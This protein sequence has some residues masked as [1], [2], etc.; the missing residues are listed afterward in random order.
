MYESKLLSLLNTFS[1]KEMRELTEFVASPYFNKNGELVDF[2]RLLRSYHPV[3]SKKKLERQ[4]FY[5]K[6]YPGETYDEKQLNYLMS[7][8]LKLAE[9]YLGISKYNSSGM[10]PELYQ[11]EALL[12]RGLDKHFQFV[13]GKT[14]TR[15]CEQTNVRSGAFYE[16]F[17]LNN[18]ANEFFSQPKHKK[19]R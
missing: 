3:F 16:E 5:K 13:H 4:A 18:L 17:L 15:L 10:L 6:L 2:T 19:I 8:T 11:S 1:S 12:D 9:R 7:F 14:K